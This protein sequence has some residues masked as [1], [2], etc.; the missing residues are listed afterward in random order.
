VQADSLSSAVESPDL[1]NSP[2]AKLAD[3]AP[4]I[5]NEI[6]V[7]GLCVRIGT[8]RC[9]SQALTIKL[10]QPLTEQQVEKALKEANPW[11][12]YVENT[13]ET[14]KTKL[15]PASV[16]GGLDIAVGRLRKLSVDPQVFSLFT[17]G[18]Q[19]LWGLLNHCG[20]YSG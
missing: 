16:S 19:L 1:K 10:N 7:D 4:D 2:D 17:V 5:I 8:L 12:R 13:P 14:S 9:H 18:D 6:R 11:V 20:E 3:V 15:T